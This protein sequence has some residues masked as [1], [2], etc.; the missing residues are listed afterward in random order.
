MATAGLD[1]LFAGRFLSGISAGL[2]TGAAT[3]YISELDGNRSRGGLLATIANMGGLGLGPLISGLLAQH[4]PS[5]TTLPYGVGI[6]LLLPGLL[7]LTVPD[8]VAR[9]PGGLRAGLTPQRLGVPSDMR[10]S[11][12]AAAIAAFVGFALLGFFTS[13][14]DSFLSKGLDNHSYQTAGIVSCLV[15]AAATAGQLA[16]G[17]FSTPT[18]LFVGLAAVPLGLGLITAALPAR[19]LPLYVIGGIVG[20]GGV[21]VAFRA[22]VLSLT[23]QAPDERRGEVLSTFFVVGYVGITLPV[24]GTGAL[25]TATT[26]FTAVVS[27]AAL[28][29]VLAAIAALILGHLRTAAARSR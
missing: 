11:F 1:G 25:V 8:T 19:S 20:G 12:A 5:P 29:A 9:R 3:A 7:V 10:V 13:L 26:L 14:V 23:A 18:A 24:I 4:A 17:R 6:V 22:A 27:L 15:F 16:S 21:G 2:V 28:L